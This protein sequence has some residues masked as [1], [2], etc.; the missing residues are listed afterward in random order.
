MD[1]KLISQEQNKIYVVGDRGVGKSSFIR[2]L[3]G[4]SKKI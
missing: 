4:I 2:T 3:I 1:D